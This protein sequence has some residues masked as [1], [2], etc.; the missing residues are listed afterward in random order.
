MSDERERIN[1]LR[2]DI[3]VLET[4]R[5]GLFERLLGNLQTSYAAG[6]ATPP[7]IHA[8]HCGRMLDFSKEHGFC[9]CIPIEEVHAR[10]VAIGTA[11][12]DVEA[13]GPG[14]VEIEHRCLRKDGR[15]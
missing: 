15:I 3:T 2:A 6:V 13:F 5:S 9:P 11:K 12:S 4:A 1:Q 8:C 10:L 14:A 7:R